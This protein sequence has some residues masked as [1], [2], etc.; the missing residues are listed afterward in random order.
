MEKGSKGYNSILLKVI[1]RQFPDATTANYNMAAIMIEGGETT[2]AKRLLDKAGD[3]PAALNNL[4]IIALLERDLDKAERVGS[5]EA[6]LNKKEVE[7]KCADNKKMER[8][9][10]RK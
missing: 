2:T 7:D 8:Y 9:K 5:K 6:A 3:S 4:G 10:N 1:P